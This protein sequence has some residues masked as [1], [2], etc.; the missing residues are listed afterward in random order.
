M[1]IIFRQSVKSSLYSYIGVLIGFVTVGFLMPKYLTQEEIGLR[2][3]IQSYAFLISSII[4]FG[5]P[6]TIVRMFPHFSNAK[7]KDHGILSLLSLISFAS[8]LVFA[9]AFHFVGKLFLKSDIENSEIFAEHYALIL[10]F[11]IATLLFISLDGYAS[12]VKESTIGTFVKDVILRIGILAALIVYILFDEVNYSDFI[13]TYTALQYVPL[14]FIILFLARKGRFQIT[15]S[16]SFPSSKIKKEFFSVSLFNWVNVIS[17][18]A[19]VSVDS[20][21]LSKLTGSADVGVYTTVNFFASLMVI[22]VKGLGKITNSII[23]EH[24]KNENLQAIK[25]IYDKSAINFLIIGLFLFGNL[26]LL[27]PFIF[28]VVLKGYSTGIGVLVFIGMAN[29]L[30]MATGVKFLLIGNSKFYKWN[31]LFLS[32]FIIS[33]II[34]NFIFIPIYGIKGAAI[35]SLISSFIHQMIGVV[36]VKTKFNFWP[37]DSQYAKSLLIFLP[38]FIGVYF[39]PMPIED[40]FG[41]IVK[42]SIFS[43]TTIYL[44]WKWRISEDLNQKLT[45]IIKTLKGN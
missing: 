25:S 21:M 45:E 16:I 14:L 8:T 22:P 40:K 11:T 36:F 24:F 34:T 43:L 3:Q 13:N 19:V 35:A 20:I 38:L 32:T 15:N 9:L 1:G 7:N 5:I 39:V 27:I 17:G 23:A 44:I 29:L 31:T 4:A 10:P 41:A 42:S 18:V 26:M 30:K 2:M 12:A 6:Q 33:L 37:F 28:N